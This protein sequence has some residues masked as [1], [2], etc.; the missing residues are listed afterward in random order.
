[1]GNENTVY[2]KDQV[3][4]LINSVVTKVSSS[5]GSVPQD[6]VLKE[7]HEL[8]KIIEETRNEIG[9]FSPQDINSKHIPTATDEL[10]AVIDATAEASGTIMD[11]CEAIQS[12][13]EGIDGEAAQKINDETIKI[14]EAC[15]FQD[16]TGQRISK[17]VT[18]LK[19]I[20]EKVQ[21]LLSLLDSGDQTAH[22][23]GAS[24]DVV[25]ERSALLNGPQM[26]D[27]AISQDDIDQLLKELDN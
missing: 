24:E 14:F 12:A 17:V 16:I 25:D 23:S 6:A 22:T 4:R 9:R 1:M 21:N 3:V 11:A 19:T 26:P 18:T 8:Q 7:L 15:S 2:A 5:Q 10:D 27:K 20:D 13:A